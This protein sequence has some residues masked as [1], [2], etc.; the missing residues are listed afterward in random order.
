MLGEQIN[1][2][3]LPAR[4]LDCSCFQS[5][6]AKRERQADGVSVAGAVL[7]GGEAGDR[8]PF[9]KRVRTDVPIMRGATMT[10]SVVEGM[11]SLE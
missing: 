7:L 6:D 8:L 1:K 9:S 10:R 3:F 4:K 11:E 2:R 5:T